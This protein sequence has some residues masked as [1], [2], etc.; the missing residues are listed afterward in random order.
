M[1]CPR[2]RGSGGLGPCPDC[3]AEPSTDPLAAWLQCTDLE[4]VRSLIDDWKADAAKLAE[5]YQYACRE[6][7][8]VVGEL[9]SAREDKEAL[10]LEVANLREAFQGA[11]ETI[12]YWRKQAEKH[13]AER[14]KQFANVAE[15]VDSL[16]CPS[17][18]IV[19]ADI[20]RYKAKLRDC[21]IDPEEV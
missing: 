10:A 2:C 13:R 9:Q 1:T 3:G 11:W 6:L 8:S 12:E 14:D 15:W 5:K 4:I 19:A 20:E 18:K 17:P 16:G 21:G 7:S